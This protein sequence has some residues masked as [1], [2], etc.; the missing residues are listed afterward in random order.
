MGIMR[1]KSNRHHST[2]YK[3]LGGITGARPRLLASTFSDS[4]NGSPQSKNADE[5]TS[6]EK[7][8]IGEESASLLSILEPVSIM[9]PEPENTGKTIGEPTGE[10]SADETQKVVEDRDRLGDDHG[11]SPDTEGD[12]DPGE[13]GELGAADHVLGVAEDALEDVGGGDVTVD[14]TSDDNGRDGDTPDDLAHG[15]R[16]SGRQSGRRNIRANE[17]VDD[18]SGEEVKGGVDNLEEGKSLGPVLRLLEL[19]DNGE[20]ARVAGERD[21][22]VG[23]SEESTSETKLLRNDDASRSNRSLMRNITNSDEHSKSNTHARSHRHPRGVLERTRKVQ[24]PKDSESNNSPDN[25]ACRA[26]GKSVDADGPGKKMASHD[27]NLEDNLR[28]TKDFLEHTTHTD[29]RSDD[30]NCVTEV[31]DVRVCFA[32]FG[33]DETGVCGQESH[34]ENEDNAGD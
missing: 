29:G 10:Q 33:E 7:K 2:E 23:N 11:Q 3:L 1:I 16:S 28:P 25:S 26:A 5:E 4:L 14:D 30:F 32:E 15:S 27:E 31:L 19:V 34:D 20:E 13:G 6:Q 12:A 9:H 8:N 24:N 17:D 18:D 21:G 22:N